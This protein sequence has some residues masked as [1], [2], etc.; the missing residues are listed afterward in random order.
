V[1]LKHGF[2]PDPFTKSLSAGGSIKTELGGVKARV[3]QAPDFKFHFTAEVQVVDQLPAPLR[4][5][6]ESKHDT[7]LL[8]KL[9]DGTWVANDD[10][11][12]NRNPQLRFGRP[13]SGW[14]T[15]WVGTFGHEKTPESGVGATLHIS[16]LPPGKTLPKK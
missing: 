10:G 3:G 11:G 8:I 7:T 13:Q 14:Y 2:T 4:I 6:V 5:Y 16:E 15:I 12:G 1:Q 9:P